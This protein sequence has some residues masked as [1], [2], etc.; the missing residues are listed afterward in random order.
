MDAGCGPPDSREMDAVGPKVISRLHRRYLWRRRGGAAL[1]VSGFGFWPAWFVNE[2]WT[3][4][5]LGGIVAAAGAAWAAGSRAPGREAVAQHLDR[6][7]P[8]LQDSAELLLLDPSVLSPLA[9]RQRETVERNLLAT[10]EATL[11]S[12]RPVQRGALVGC[13]FG[14]IGLMG[15]SWN[16][17]RGNAIAEQ[18]P[19]VAAGELIEEVEILAEIT[20]LVEPPSYT[21]LP[22]LTESGLGGEIIV[23]TRVTWEVRVDGAV[24][25]LVFESQSGDQTLRESSSGLWS[26]SL[27]PEEDLPLRLLAIHEG[28]AR[29]LSEWEVLTVRLDE[30]PAVRISSPE[31]LLELDEGAVGSLSLRV[32]VSD[33]FGLGSSVLVATLAQGAGENV[34][35]RERRLSLP[36][37]RGSATDRKIESSLD[38]RAMGL[39]PG[40]ELIFHVE[41]LDRQKPEPQVGRSGSRIVRVRGG[42]EGPIGLGRGLPLLTPPE[43]FRSQRQIILDTEA[44]LEALPN[45]APQEI[46]RRSEA[47]GFDQR[48]LRMRYGIL[49]GEENVEAGSVAVG[50]EHEDEGSG[51]SHDV[52]DHNEQQSLAGG[53]AEESPLIAGVPGDLAH[54]HDSAEMAT[55]FSDPVRLGLRRALAAMWDSESRLRGNEPRDALPFER[56]ALEQLQAL[57][58]ATRV[59]VNRIGFDAPALD[60]GRRLGGE[61]D[62]IVSRVPR[63]GQALLEDPLV[64]AYEMLVD[65]SLGSEGLADVLDSLDRVVGKELSGPSRLRWLSIRSDLREAIQTGQPVSSELKSSLRETLWGWLMPPQP[66]PT[67]RVV[68]T[69]RSDSGVER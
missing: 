14:L 26:W 57:K 29:A 38:L 59:Y 13:C 64:E 49:L 34:E 28:E 65:E 46:R 24:D 1:M 37:G 10:A 56:I 58:R 44:L 6:L 66:R 40:S 21:G 30:A 41:T 50:V 22:T 19:R 4:A 7:L 35:F 39:E 18:I 3:V 17:P 2:S 25:E 69:A 23:G 43:V 51:D 60:E 67:L 9:R 52:E 53:L 45:L 63:R 16:Q 20:R 48:A 62:E 5:T 54:A 15:F 12:W 61:L 68:P 42:T 36:Q 11:L 33:D 47:I 27:A 8:S 31:R 32:H 55:F